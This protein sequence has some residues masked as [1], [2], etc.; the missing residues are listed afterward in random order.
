MARDLG[1]EVYLRQARAHQRRKDQQPVLRRIRQPAL[2]LCGAHDTVTPI[3]RH[4][5][6]AE[7]IP[8]AEFR[9]FDNA[10]HVPTLEVPDEV[11]ETIG[12]WMCQPL[13]LR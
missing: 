12:D 2:V 13:V 6:M 10:G 4:E 7:M 9:V 11:T 3:K 8:Y 5:F 1:P